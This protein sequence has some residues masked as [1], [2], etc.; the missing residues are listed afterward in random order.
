MTLTLAFDI[1]GTLIDTRG[2]ETTLTGMVG[3]DAAA[4]SRTWRDKQLEYA[5][6]RGLMGRYQPFS[7]CTRQALDF[8]LAFH[9]HSLQADQR[10]QLLDCYQHLPAFTDALPAL[11]SLQAEGYQ[12][13]AFSNGQATAVDTLL[14]NAGLRD[15][16]AGIVSVDDVHSFKPDPKVYAHFLARTNAEAATTWLVS[17]NPFDVIGARSAGW[18]AAWIQR[19]AA[20]VFDPWELAPSQTLSALTELAAALKR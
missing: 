16:F 5:F 13:W 8:A 15:C 3:S 20:V 10:Q 2:V 19:S 17:S 9:Q 1:Y 7:E 12:L 6:R 11:H 18:Q 14:V 4:V